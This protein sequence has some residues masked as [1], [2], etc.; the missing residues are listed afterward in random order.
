ML[1]IS[2]RIIFKLDRL[3]QFDQIDGGDQVDSAFEKSDIHVSF[4]LYICDCFGKIHQLRRLLQKRH[5][6]SSFPNKIEGETKGRFTYFMHQLEWM[7]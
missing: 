4:A 2:Y 1:C 5:F 3:A 7:H 6:P